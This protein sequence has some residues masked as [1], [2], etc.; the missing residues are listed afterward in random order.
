MACASAHMPQQKCVNWIAV[1]FFLLE[2]FF[3]S[4]LPI[5]RSLLPSFLLRFHSYKRRIV[6]CRI[7]LLVF[8]LFWQRRMNS[9]IIENSSKNIFQFFPDNAEYLSFHI[10]NYK[11][12]MQQKKRFENLTDLI[13]GHY[14]KCP[15]VSYQ[16]CSNCIPFS[17]LSC[18]N[19][20][21]SYHRVKLNERG[22][23]ELPRC[24]LCGRRCLDLTK[25]FERGKNDKIIFTYGN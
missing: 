21:H 1:Y 24:D 18:S 25:H 15:T 20:R 7:F 13:F 22:W 17:A 3:L 12:R 6:N 4:P 10:L 8:C 2:F 16:L 5:S 9:E 14:H 11:E 23:K 19:Y